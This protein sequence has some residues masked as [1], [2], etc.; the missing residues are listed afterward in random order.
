MKK[1]EEVKASVAGL[2]KLYGHRMRLGL[3]G[4]LIVNDWVDFVTLRDALKLTDGSLAGHIK[5]LTKAGQ[6]EVEKRFVGD[7]PRTSYRATPD[8][9]AAFERHLSELEDFLKIMEN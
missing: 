7:K 2:S 5:A 3:M 8:G 1:V 4:I 6:I 9:R